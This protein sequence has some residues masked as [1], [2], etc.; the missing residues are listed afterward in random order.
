M[1]LLGV[2]LLQICTS[3]SKDDFPSVEP[4]AYQTSDTY[5]SPQR[6]MENLWDFVSSV[7][8]KTRSVSAVGGK[9]MLYDRNLEEI[10]RSTEQP[11]IYVLNFDSGGFAVLS[12]TTQLPSVLA[13]SNEGE[14]DLMQEQEIP[15]VQDFVNRL[16]LY[17]N[18]RLDSMILGD[19]E[20]YYEYGD[21][22]TKEKVGP[23]CR[24]KWHQDAP[25]NNYMPIINGRHADA[26][27]GPIAMAQAM[28]VYMWPNSYQNNEFNW[29]EMLALSPSETGISM[30]A[31]LIEIIGRPELADV[32]FTPQGTGCGLDDLIIAFKKL[33]YSNVTT[34]EEKYN[35]SGY[36]PIIVNDELRCNRPVIVRGSTSKN[37]LSPKNVTHFWL[38]HGLFV[39]NRTVNY[40]HRSD[41]G[42]PELISSR[43]ETITYQQCNWGWGGYMD[44]YYLSDVYDLTDGIPYPEDDD[45]TQDIGMYDF[46]YFLDAIIE[47]YPDR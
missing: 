41:I 23:L 12:A 15:G 4:I 11:V 19:Q 3:C 1:L 31:R 22:T 6:A 13:Y 24:V 46:Q 34:A 10:T 40:W 29:P 28:S 39:Q 37:V 16:K 47:I 38:L 20:Y 44:G 18:E 17:S 27:C 21:W 25:Y 14:I 32:V 8:E 33:Q 45:H 2:L 35:V 7:N 9:W 26:G 30:V 36:N 5:I 43:E 42:Q